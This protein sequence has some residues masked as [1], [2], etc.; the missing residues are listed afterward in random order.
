MVIQK[1]DLVAPFAPG[2]GFKPLMKKWGLG[3][4]VVALQVAF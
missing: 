3:E 2:R 1:K 4:A